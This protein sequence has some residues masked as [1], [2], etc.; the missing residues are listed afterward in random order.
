MKGK[1]RVGEM[2]GFRLRARVAATFRKIARAVDER[3]A[4]RKTHDFYRSSGAAWTRSLAPETT[5][6]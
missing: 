1:S 2:L 3:T 5:C 4:N 6:R